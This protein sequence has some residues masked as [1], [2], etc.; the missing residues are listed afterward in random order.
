MI[1]EPIVKARLIVEVD[2]EEIPDMSDLRALM[3]TLNEMGA[4]RI[5]KFVT[6]QPYEVDLT[7]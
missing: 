6:L 1:R 5:A 3:D 2:Y 4:V 7:Q